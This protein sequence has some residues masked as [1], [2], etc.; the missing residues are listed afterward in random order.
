MRFSSV[1]LPTAAYVLAAVLLVAQP[2]AQRALTQQMA[3]DRLGFTVRYPAGWSATQDAQTI[4]I[5]KAPRVQARA[6]RAVDRT[7][8]IYVTSE[9]RLTHENAVRRLREIASERNTPPTYLTI[10]GW[11]AL[12][13]RAVIVKEQP[14]N[15]EDPHPEERVISI[16]T[17][18]AAGNQVVRADAR[19]PLDTPRA[20]EDQ[21]RAIGAGLLFRSAGSAPQTTRD[22]RALRAAPRLKPEVAPPSKV[23]PTPLRQ[24]LRAGTLARGPARFTAGTASATP[25][26]GAGTPTVPTLEPGLALRVIPGG[27]AS[28]PEIAVSNNGQNIVIG[29]QSQFRTSNDGGQTFPFSGSFTTDDG[30]SSLAFGRSGN[31]YEGTINQT[32]SAL[33]FSQDGGRTF[34]FGANAFTCPTTG[35]NQC[36]FARGNP[37]AP[38]PDQ[39]HIA[40]DRLN[41]A[42]AGGDQVYFAFRLGGGRYG[43]ACSTDS[44]QNFGAP[45]FTNGDFPRITVGPD[46]FVYVVAQNG[47]NVEI[48]RW[49]SCQAGFAQTALYP[50]VVITGASDTYVNCPMPGLDRCNGGANR[51]HSHMVAVD[52]TNPNHIF[53]AYAQSTSA[54]NENVVIRDSVDAG[55]N[56]PAA[57][58]VTVSS[59][60]T[61]RR[62][63]P[64]VCAVGGVAHASWYDRRTATGGNVDLTDYYAGSAFVDALN[65]LV[66]GGEVQINAPGSADPQCNAGKTTGSAQSWP[67]GSRAANDSAACPQP[68]LAGQCRHTPNNATDSKNACNLNAAAVCPLNETCQLGGGVPKYGDYNGNV[69]AA[70]RL[71]TI[72]S[73]ATPP[74]GTAAT[75]NVDLY[76]SSAILCCAPQ[77]QIPGPVVFPD[78]CAGSSSLQTANVC[79]AGKA[80]LRI[81]PIT[82]SNPQFSVTPPSS[83]Y[84]LTLAPGACFPFQ[85][86][87]TPSGTGLQNGTLTVPSNDPVTPSASIAVSGTAGQPAIATA[88]ADSGDFGT[89]C[90]GKFRDLEVTLHNN[91]ACPL[92]VTGMSSSSA[93]FKMASVVSFPLT[94]APGGSIELPVRFEPGSA[95]AK[96][97]ALTVNSNDP[98]RPSALIRVKGVGGQP[99]IATIIAD[100]GDFGTV[101]RGV[102][103]DLPLTIQNSG[104]CPLT[105]TNIVSSSPEFQTAQVL[106][107]PLVI[108][109]GGSLEV[110]IRFRPASSGNKTAT[111]TISSDDPAAPTKTV[112]VKGITPPEYICH[113]P[114]FAVAG[115]NI[116][117]TFGPSR[118][119]DYGFTGYGRFLQP[120]GPRKTYGVQAQGEYL[121]YEGRQE[122]QFDGGLLSRIHRFQVGAFGDFKY[123]QFRPSRIG[124]SLGQAAFTLDFLFL[125]NARF[126]VFGTKGFRD[127]AGLGT[128]RIVDQFG[129]SG[130]VQ[131]PHRTYFEGNLVYLKRHALGLDDRPG[132]M[133]RFVHQFRPEIGFTVEGDFNETFVGRH[134]SG[135]VVFGVQFGHWPRPRDLADRRNPL[136]TDIPRVHYEVVGGRR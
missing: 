65:N 108:A 124:N 6:G 84:P 110:P 69:C 79:N 61:A 4:W 66:P 55:V 10:G 31:F 13:R 53:V 2:A 12:Q 131:L 3:V 18:I 97:A 17:A 109:P 107:Y 46:G 39:E 104:S 35:P 70:G 102:F 47:N 99:V 112:T 98:T 95:G 16:T 44:G 106:S 21:V 101:C 59:A 52:D 60:V 123:A 32:S 41:A 121:Y 86:K 7:A 20:V 114:T 116:G 8:Q 130:Q 63:M 24:N 27:F 40:A 50:H 74:P 125:H 89:V 42:T 132:A 105:V 14:A 54:T 49:S 75:G 103:R 81:D 133:L 94:I 73:S 135:R 71:Y 90:P 77:I 78:T 122:G 45:Q 57:R 113:P 23:K 67:A 48:N 111:I 120:F 92:I 37:A 30:D 29:Q 9:N 100:T 127:E 15:D 93:E 28:E 56:W 22:L 134:D 25:A 115:V 136:G 33:N 118:T 119:G 64:W 62:F 76:F 128:L 26:G 11:P 43:V 36:G 87:F 5:V 19:M 129:G 1:F 117:P 88:I 58:V 126:G 34:S 85:V 80:D 38:F 96:S 82:S 68:Q 72:W 51:L 91:G 83:N